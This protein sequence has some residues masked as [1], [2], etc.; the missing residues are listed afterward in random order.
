MEALKKC[1]ALHKCILNE[2]KTP[3]LQ[4][5]LD[6]FTL[7]HAYMEHKADDNEHGVLFLQEDID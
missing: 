4:A 6:N 7:S 2:L 3:D 5:V 1:A